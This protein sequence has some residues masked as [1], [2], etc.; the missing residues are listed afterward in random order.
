MEEFI[1]RKYK[2]EI[3]AVYSKIS[4]TI[5]RV[6]DGIEKEKVDLTIRK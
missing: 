3:Y 1:V 5:K 2:H 6:L 4:K